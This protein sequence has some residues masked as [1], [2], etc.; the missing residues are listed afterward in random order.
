MQQ[1]YLLQAGAELVLG[2]RRA[3][4]VELRT[5][6]EFIGTGRNSLLLFFRGYNK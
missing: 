2:T 4:Y 1:M 6:L 5:G 3:Y